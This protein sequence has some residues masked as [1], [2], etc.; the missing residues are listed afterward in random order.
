MVSSEVSVTLER[1]QAVTAYQPCHWWYYQAQMGRGH[2]CTRLIWAG[3]FQAKRVDL[4]VEQFGNSHKWVG[5]EVLVVVVAVVISRGTVG[6]TVGFRHAPSPAE[7]LSSH[8][9]VPEAQGEVD[10]TDDRESQYGGA[11]GFLS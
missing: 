10:L 9:V 6:K 8:R 2:D 11:D 3:S 7:L 5:P 4:E 1:H